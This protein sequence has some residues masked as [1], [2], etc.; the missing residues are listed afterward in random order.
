MVWL[1]KNK[2]KEDPPGNY[3]LD[4]DKC[5]KKKNIICEFDHV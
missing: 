3:C 1:F 5:E 2:S 4:K